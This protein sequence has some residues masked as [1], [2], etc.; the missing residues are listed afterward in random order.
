MDLLDIALASI[1]F[2]TLKEKILVKA[3][4]DSLDKLALLSIDDIS[5][6]I[7]R[8]IKRAT[9]N[10]KE[11]VVQVQR[12]A[13]LMEKQ[14]IETVL[15]SD[16]GYPALLREI[17]DPPYILFYRGNLASLQKE[18]VSVVGT[19]H[20]C[21]E[22]AIAT[23][24]F[25]F[26]AAKDNVTVISGNA[27]GIDF[28]AHKG[29]LLSEAFAS[30]VAIL[31]C[32]IDSIVPV[33]HK[34]LVERMLVTGGAVASEYIPGCPAE[35]WRFVQRNRIIAALSPATVVIQ[36]PPGSG[37]LITA[38]LALDFNREVMFHKSCFC[39]ESKKMS[40]LQVQKLEKIA[41][42]SK[43]SS[44]SRSAKNKLANNIEHYV[45]DGAPVIENYKDYRKVR[46][47]VPGAYSL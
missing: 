31:P 41:T 21:Q 34:A 2:L 3:N 11:T 44:K 27:N 32:G 42:S 47:G 14:H 35:P 19:R 4:I 40:L 30:T 26:D 7:G 16:G 9:W 24:Q 22:C 15:Y 37:A 6:I 39:E 1:P 10:A 45:E 38:S 25:A 17:L 28:F 18:C 13:A 36:A 12:G 23:Q 29:A 8:V 43:I 5:L 33:G 46:N 20:V